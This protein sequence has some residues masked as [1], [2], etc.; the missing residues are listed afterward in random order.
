MK[1][2]MIGIS[3]LLIALCLSCCS[4]E[5]IVTNIETETPECKNSEM[6]ELYSYLRESNY[7]N[8]QAVVLEASYVGADEG[9]RFGASGFGNIEL[10]FFTEKQ[11]TATDEG[12]IYTSAKSGEVEI[13][14]T[15]YKSAVS[16][17]GNI[18]MLYASDVDTEKL[19]APNLLT[20]ILHYPEKTG[21]TNESSSETSSK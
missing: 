17:D 19:Q 18:V 9:Y 3:A 12:N 11:K 14:G 5:G 15:K 10:Y 21:Y 6:Q 1:R 20:E 8:E 2:I 13:F 4:M 7:I 16:S